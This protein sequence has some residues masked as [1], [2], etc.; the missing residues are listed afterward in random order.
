MLAIKFKKIGKRHQASFRIV[1]TEKRSKLEGRYV[2]DI[3]WMNPR[4]DTVD[5]K[6]ER[7]AYWIT[8]GAQPTDSVHNLLV[9]QGVIAGPKKPVHGKKKVAQESK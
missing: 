4:E 5:V 2:E 6:K 8:K 7:A 3:G 1:V 9:K